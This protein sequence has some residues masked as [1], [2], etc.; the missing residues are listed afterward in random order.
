[1]ILG[2]VNSLKIFSQNYLHPRS[3]MVLYNY[4]LIRIWRI[5]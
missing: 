1:M 3:S 4:Q 2:P 5:K